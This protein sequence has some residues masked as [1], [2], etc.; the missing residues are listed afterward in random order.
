MAPAVFDAIFGVGAMFCF[1]IGCL[2]NSV[3]LIYFLKCKG[4]LFRITQILYTYIAIVDLLT[5]GMMLPIAASSLS[6]RKPLLF[7]NSVFCNIHGF[8]WNI[9][10]RLSIFLVMVLSLTRT[11]FL[12]MPFK[13][14]DK[15][16]VLLSIVIYCVI[17]MAQAAIPYMANVVYSYEVYHVRCT[18]YIFDVSPSLAISHLLHVVLVVI[19]ILIP[20]IPVTLSCIISTRVLFM[21]VRSPAAV[22]ISARNTTVRGKHKRKATITII[23]ITM[24]YVV[25]NLPPSLTAITMLVDE[26]L[27]NWDRFYFFSNFQEVH[28]VALN[29]CLNPIIYL[30]TMNQMK[31]FLIS[32]FGNAKNH[33]S[34]YVSSAHQDQN[35]NPHHAHRSRIQQMEYQEP[36]SLP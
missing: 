22:S 28:C 19:P 11:V 23:A 33:I 34:A 27:M 4:K 12:T 3:S 16:A 15:R 25:F 5:S 24:V 6:Q 21:T 1:L 14:L 7:S 31:Q 8:L 13:K 30:M 9:T 32:G 17:Q 20:I 35:H 26:K 10:S 18:W 29:A 2:G 36:R